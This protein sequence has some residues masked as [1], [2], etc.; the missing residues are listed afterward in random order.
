MTSEQI[1][2][3]L[4]RYR[5]NFTEIMGT[6]VRGHSSYRIRR[7]DD[8]V[9]R[10]LIIEII[11]LLTDAMGDNKYSKMIAAK[12][13]E[14]TYNQLQTP[15]YKSIEDIVSIIDSV[16][17][18][19]N[20]NPD[21]YIKKEE[22]TK[23]NEPIKEEQDAIMRTFHGVPL[24]HELE[25][26]SDIDLAELQSQLAHDSPG[27]IIIENEWQR[28]K[29]SKEPFPT[30]QRLQELGLN[31][32][33]NENNMDPIH[34]PSK[35]TIGWLFQLIRRLSLGSWSLLLFVVGGSFTLGYQ[36]GQLD[37]RRVITTLQN[38]QRSRSSLA[39]QASMTTARKVNST[40]APTKKETIQK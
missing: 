24:A 27:K 5:F 16:V 12:F 1:I 30:P 20:R 37:L 8:P 36:L 19:L 15:S 23:P 2:Q 33:Q 32:P 28:R 35:V 13:K 21:F 39:M 34:L 6:F 29:S 18:R 40:P 22:P 25:A 14:G 3:E 9:Y 17:T 31:H 7:E 38:Q 11:D 4:E 10:T 26:M